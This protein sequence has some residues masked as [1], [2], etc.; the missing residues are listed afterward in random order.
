MELEGN[1]YE[2]VSYAS[3]AGAFMNIGDYERA[4]YYFNK[5]MDL[6][7]DCANDRRYRWLL[8]VRGRFNQA[9]EYI[10]SKCKSGVCENNCSRN[11]FKSYW[12]LGEYEKAEQYFLLWKTNNQPSP[13][14][15]NDNYEIGHVYYQ[16]GRTEEAAQIFTKEIQVL[17]SIV[18]STGNSNRSVRR[19]HLHLSRIYAFQGKRKEAIE[20]LT[21]Y[22]NSGFLD[23]WHDFILL[24]PF[25]ESLRDD[26]EFKAIVK[27]AQEEK[28]TQRAQIKE[29]EE[30]G[31]LTL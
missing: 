5:L 30:R 25:F 15:Y 21:E 8:Q 27:Q 12:L 10:N 2:R 23:G 6:G 22:A 7:V 20:H 11:L 17:Q 1:R 9:F 28:A 31:E 16:L 19:T 3:L 18:E 24:D 14:Y 13:F 29:M 26:P 4:S